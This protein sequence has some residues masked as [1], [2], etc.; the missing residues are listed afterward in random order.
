RT[1][2]KSNHPD[3]L[4]G[5]SRFFHSGQGFG[6]ARTTPPRIRRS[7]E[8]GRVSSPA[9]LFADIAPQGNKAFRT[10]STAVPWRKFHIYR[11]FDP[12]LAGQ[13]SSSRKRTSA[14]IADFA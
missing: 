4:R 9:M 3:E 10:R 6:L 14:R 12:W 2:H 8:S 7:T 5:A 11:R 1:D 13:E